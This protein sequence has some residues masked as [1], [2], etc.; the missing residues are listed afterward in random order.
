MGEANKHLAVARIRERKDYDTGFRVKCLRKLNADIYATN[1]AATDQSAFTDNGHKKQTIKNGL[2][3]TKTLGT[4]KRHGMLITQG[5]LT[6][7]DIGDQ[8]RRKAEHQHQNISQRQ[9]CDEVVRRIAH[10][11]TTINHS[12]DAGI[13][14]KSN[15]EDE[16][17]CCTKKEVDRQLMS[18]KLNLLRSVSWDIDDNGWG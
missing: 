12:D 7:K 16:K 1:L 8:I 14:D 5:I 18:K 15:D 4:K 10:A 6:I 17:I 9:V 13:S 3:L 2:H 11:R